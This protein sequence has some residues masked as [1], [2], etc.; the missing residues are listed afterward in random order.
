MIIWT[1]GQFMRGRKKF[2]GQSLKYG[3]SAQFLGGAQIFLDFRTII[4][5]GAQIF[6]AAQNY[7]RLIQF[8]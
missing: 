6:V 1:V 5:T 7:L 3:R 8:S 2:E 4:W